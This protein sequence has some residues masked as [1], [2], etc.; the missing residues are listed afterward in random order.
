MEQYIKKLNDRNI[1]PTSI[2]LLIIKAM[3]EFEH[4]FS[5][6]D[7]E[8]KL[9]TVDKST[10][11]RTIQLFQENGIIHSIDDGTH[12]LKYSVCE[13]TCECDINDLHT[14]FHCRSCN[15]T[16]CLNAIPIPK[17]TLPAGFVLENANFVLKGICMYCTKYH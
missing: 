2:R 16:Y 1:K 17:V 3:M 10:I 13:D 12:S 14:H 8:L 5:L 6:F 7:L 4:A 11:Y 9:E 15:Q